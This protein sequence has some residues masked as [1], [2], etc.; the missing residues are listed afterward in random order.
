MN[1]TRNTLAVCAATLAATIGVIGANHATA[2]YEPAPMPTGHIVPAAAVR[3][4]DTRNGDTLPHTI[5]PE[6]ARPPWAN[7]AVVNVAVIDPDT[8]G[9][10]TFWN[11]DGPPPEVAHL[12]YTTAPITSGMAYA[13]LGAGGVICAV[14]TG[15]GGLVVDVQAWTVTAQ[16]PVLP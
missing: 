15:G 6:A 11:C 10:V 2:G 1:L 5:A 12:N 9:F 14:S 4:L 8:A 7:V 3:V 13:P 16:T